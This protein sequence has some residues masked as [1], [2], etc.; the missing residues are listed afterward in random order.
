MAQSP[1]D[2]NGNADAGDARIPSEWYFTRVWDLLES[3]REVFRELQSLGVEVCQTVPTK[4]G[5]VERPNPDNWILL[6]TEL[7][8]S[9]DYRM[10]LRTEY[11]APDELEDLTIDAAAELLNVTSIALYHRVRRAKGRGEGTPFQRRGED[12]RLVAHRR[13]VLKWRDSWT[14]R[15]GQRRRRS[16]S[17]D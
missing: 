13:D 9:D 15:H 16:P 12:G 8:L 4:A 1:G 14:G 6:Q 2:T 17:P 3:A 11:M 5:F 7:M 10:W